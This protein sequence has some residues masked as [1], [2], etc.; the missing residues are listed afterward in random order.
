MY[1]IEIYTTVADAIAAHTKY[2]EEQGLPYED[3]TAY[4]SMEEAGTLVFGDLQD[5]DDWEDFVENHAEDKKVMDAVATR[6]F[7]FMDWFVPA[8]SGWS[9]N[10]NTSYPMYLIAKG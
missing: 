1:N 7:I 10:P 8:S 4:T 3:L 6:Q 9:F 2:R 5:D